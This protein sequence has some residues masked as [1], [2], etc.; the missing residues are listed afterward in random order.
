MNDDW[1]KYMERAA[2]LIERGYVT[3][4]TVEELARHLRDNSVPNLPM[5]L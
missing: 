2:L 5:K 4:M 1:H 3:G